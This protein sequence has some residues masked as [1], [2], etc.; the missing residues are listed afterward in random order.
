[1]GTLRL[2]SRCRKDTWAK[3]DCVNCGAPDPELFELVHR[4]GQRRFGSEHKH[5]GQS[6]CHICY[7]KQ[8]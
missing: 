1:M 4:E 6:Y 5:V 3:R 7:R 2:C 8:A